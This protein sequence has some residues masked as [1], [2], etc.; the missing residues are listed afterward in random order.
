[1]PLPAWFRCRAACNMLSCDAM[2][3]CLWPA[4]LVTLREVREIV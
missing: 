2:L 3:R 1:M 4:W